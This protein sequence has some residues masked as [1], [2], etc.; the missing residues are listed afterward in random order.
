MKEEIRRVLE[1]LEALYKEDNDGETLLGRI[2][3]IIQRAA[4]D[5]T[6]TTAMV[7]NLPCERDGEH[8]TLAMSKE[9]LQYKS[10]IAAQDLLH[11]LLNQIDVFRSQLS[12]SRAMLSACVE[13]DES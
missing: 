12:I 10:L 1:C 8:I 9:Y 4:S 5:G 3:D 13:D 2:E 6:A 7:S 11:T